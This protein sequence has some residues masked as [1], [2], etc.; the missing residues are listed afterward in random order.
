M[1]YLFFEYDGV[2][3]GGLFSKVQTKIVSYLKKR[4]ATAEDERPD[5]KRKVMRFKVISGGQTGVDQLALSVAM[6]YGFKTGGFAP[7]GF[8]TST[9]PDT[10]LKN[11]FEMQEM[12]RRYSVSRM[13]IERSKRNVDC[14]DVTIA[15][16]VND[17]SV[18]TLKTIGYC[19]TKKWQKSGPVA[20]PHRPCL[21]I[22]DMDA[23]D[24][25]S[26]IVEFILSHTPRTVNICGHRSDQSA[27]QAGFCRRVRLLFMAVF[28]TLRHEMNQ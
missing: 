28:Q 12:P 19:R 10:T 6:L 15:I 26:R 7:H 16:C 18:G 22:D 1:F 2:F 17:T 21:V 5:K 14:S 13:Y 27:S 23:K 9:G 20:I 24:N 8:L 25:P 11:L 3:W 4:K